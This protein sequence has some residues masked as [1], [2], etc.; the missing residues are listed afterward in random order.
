MMLLW[1]M[2]RYVSLSSLVKPSRCIIFICLAIVLLPLS[3]VPV[4]EK[5]KVRRCCIYNA[6]IKW[7]KRNHRNIYVYTWKENKE[8]GARLSGTICVVSR[9]WYVKVC[10]VC[11]RIW[12]GKIKESIWWEV[13]GIGAIH[14]KIPTPTGKWRKGVKGH[15]RFT[16]WILKNMGD[17]AWGL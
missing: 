2:E 9:W 4:G 8:S 15:E 7:M 11:T 1:R 17:S 6:D 13:V 5:R 10:K 14:N 3:P 16:K 12:K